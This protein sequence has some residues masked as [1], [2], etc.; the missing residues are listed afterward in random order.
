MRVVALD[1]ATLEGGAVSLA[2]IEQ[3]ADELIRHPATPAGALPQRVAGA[4][5]WAQTQWF[6]CLPPG[7]RVQD[8][9]PALQ[10]STKSKLYFFSFATDCKYCTVLIWQHLFSFFF[11][12]FQTLENLQK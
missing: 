6:W 12:I 2:A 3:V 9:L 10:P 7:G 4:P 5:F 8:A 1:A 11:G